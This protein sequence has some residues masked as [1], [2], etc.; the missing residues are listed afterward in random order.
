MYEFMCGEVPFGANC[1]DPYEIFKL[2]TSNPDIV[3]PKHFDHNEN[4]Y[5]KLLIGQL[6]SRLPEPRLG[7]SYAALKAHKWFDKFDWVV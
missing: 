7:G 4:K 5:G 2:I 6:L 1:K 3:Y